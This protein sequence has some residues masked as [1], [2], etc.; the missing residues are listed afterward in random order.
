MSGDER[1]SKKFIN[2]AGKRAKG[3]FTGEDGSIFW[4]IKE[5]YNAIKVGIQ[6][7]NVQLSRAGRYT[8]ESRAKARREEKRDE[9]D[10][11]ILDEGLA[12][13]ASTEAQSDDRSSGNANG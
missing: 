9:R 6:A 12:D 11:D 4:A 1:A 8:D 7:L 2:N 5:I 3:A 13:L 10:V